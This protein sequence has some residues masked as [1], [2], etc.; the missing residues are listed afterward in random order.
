MTSEIKKKSFSLS[1]K[2]LHWLIAGHMS[3]LIVSGWWIVDLS[4]YSSW[5]Y[6]APALHKSFGAVVFLMGLLLRKRPPPLESHT[7]LEKLASKFAHLLLFASLITIPVSGYIFTTFTGQN[8]SIFNTF[9]I[10]VV[11]V[12]SEKI[13]DLAIEFHIYAS[14]GIAVVVFVHAGG[15]LKHHLLDKDRT[16]RRMLW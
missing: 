12:T 15:A 13:R 8:V 3:G 7:K 11:L 1:T 2:L 6:S 10:P 4:F 5:Y 16:L 14:Y 9:D